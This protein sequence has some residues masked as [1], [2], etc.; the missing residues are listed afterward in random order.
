MTP[1][2]G[3]TRLGRLLRRHRRAPAYAWEQLTDPRARRGRRFRLGQLVGV[4][5]D[6]LCAAL[7]ALR[8]VESL[9]G[10]RPG[11][12][13]ISDTTLFALLRRLEPGPVRR[14]LWAQVRG[15]SR[16]K[17][18]RPEGLPFGV[19]AV[20]GK[21]IG[22]LEHDADGLAQKAHRA[23]DGSPYWLGRVLR[24]ALVSA[25]SCPCVDQMPV[26]ASTNEMTA[27]EDFFTGLV[28]QYGSIDLFEVAAVAAGLRLGAARTVRGRGPARPRALVAPAHRYR[29]SPGPDST[30]RCTPGGGQGPRLAR[31]PPRAQHRPQRPPER[32][33]RRAPR[34]TDR[35]WVGSNGRGRGGLSCGIV[36]G[37]PCRYRWGRA[38]G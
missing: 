6:G 36:A 31:R 35:V 33:T 19:L 5:F 3:A 8:D 12:R 37:S 30:A 20:D 15:L 21:G 27:F 1:L 7:L 2:S 28:R 29:P 17:S 10:E 26:P 16:S 25:P 9:S 22:A 38:A 18:L 34:T 11:G 23:R 13:R 14:R 32:P 24:A 4:L